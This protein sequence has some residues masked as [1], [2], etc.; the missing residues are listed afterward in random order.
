MPRLKKASHI[1]F[2]GVFRSIEVDA[3]FEVTEADCFNLG[4]EKVRDL[5]AFLLSSSSMDCFSEKVE[6]I[7]T[8]DHQLLT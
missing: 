4:G 5:A 7:R 3:A 2:Q 8:R 1:T 6:T